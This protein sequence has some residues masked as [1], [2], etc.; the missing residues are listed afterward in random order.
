MFCFIQGNFLSKFLS[1]S[2]NSVLF[3]KTATSSLLPKFVCDNL[4][5]KFSAVILLNSGVVIYLL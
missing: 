3:T 4:A 1:L 2:S 5:A